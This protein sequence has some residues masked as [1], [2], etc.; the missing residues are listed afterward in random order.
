MF[1]WAPEMCVRS[2]HTRLVRL[3]LKTFFS[4]PLRPHLYRYQ[5]K[6]NIAM[7][8]RAVLRKKARRESVKQKEALP[9][10]K[11]PRVYYNGNSE[12]LRDT[13]SVSHVESN[14]VAPAAPV[15]QWVSTTGG[16]V[17]PE[18]YQVAPPAPARKVVR[19]VVVTPKSPA[20]E[21]EGSANEEETGAVPSIDAVAGPP[22]SLEGLTHKQRKKL[23]T[24]ARHEKQM[25]RLVENAA[26]AA[27]AAGPSEPAA[28]RT[29]AAEGDKEGHDSTHEGDDDDALTPVVLPG[30]LER[31][32]PRFT[33][34]TYWRDRKERRGRTLFLG[35][36]SARFTVEKVKE[37]ISTVVDTDPGAVDYL[38]Q[39]PEGTPVVES[40]DMLNDNHSGKVRHM[41]VVMASVPLAFIASHKLDG[42]PMEQR[43][44]RCNFAADKTQRAE[45]IKRRGPEDGA[46]RGRG[47]FGGG[48][49]GGAG[50]G[51]GR[52]VGR[53]FAGHGAS[54]G[55]FGDEV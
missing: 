48:R 39:L 42:M 37:F 36:L 31:H 26:R 3:P 8:S 33:N 20:A 21:R 38:A 15:Q 24:K 47:G 19:R 10:P 28:A 17:V 11:A 22:V 51:F 5:H 14:P 4:L 52:G 9:T 18:R 55:G 41:Y 45:A 16:T 12:Q 53:G 46:A 23:E 49:G 54:S 1:L 43:N 44:I 35:G 32:D 30:P 7:P 50:R 34:G 29:V 2:A 6:L 27:A 13:P 40:V 25:A